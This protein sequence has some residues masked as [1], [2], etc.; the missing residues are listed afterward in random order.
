MQ[1]DI[2]RLG[3][4]DLLL[5][6]PKRHVDSRGYF[7]ET[8]NQEAFAEIGI[9]TVFVQDNHSLS[10]KAGTIRG[11][12]FQSAPF[13]QSKLVRVLRGRVF[14]VAVDIRRSSSTFG[15]YVSV[16]LSAQD[17]GQILIPAGFAH[18]FCTLEPETEV[19]YKVDQYYSASHDRGIRW[20]D[21]VIGI[22]WPIGG[23]A[24]TLSEKD[25]N[26]PLL[27]DAQIL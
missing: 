22:D 3:I 17:G 25:K 27:A 7:V 14:D 19:V 20:D 10:L 4:P 21:P 11:L 6:R 12:H 1:F 5:I 23:Q 16:E 2:E 9:H 13:A 18:G 26:L 24:A 15:R 8:Y